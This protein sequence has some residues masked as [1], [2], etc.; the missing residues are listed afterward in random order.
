VKADVRQPRTKTILVAAGGTGGHLFPAQALAIELGKRGWRIELATD[1]RVASYGQDFP[2]AEV[3]LIKSATPSGGGALGKIGAALKLALGTVAA[4]SVIRRV[5]PSAAIGFGGYPTV[6][7]I[8]AASMLGVPC[9]V[10]EA[11]AVL[12]RANKFLVTRVQ[13]VATSSAHVKVSAASG[14]EV[15]ETGNPMRPAVIEASGTPYP[16]RGADDP[17]RL[18]VFG[19]SQGARVFS[20]LV[21]PALE[22]LS[23]GTRARLQITQQCREEDLAAVRAKYDALGLKAELAPFFRDLPARIAGSH[24]VIARSGAGTVSELAVIGRPAIL[25]PL[26]GSIDQDQRANAKAI[27][28]VGGAVLIDQKELTPERLASELSNFIDHPE[29]LAEAARKAKSF[30]RPDA[31]QRLADL[32][33]AVAARKGNAIERH[34]STSSG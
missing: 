27:A 12:G 17:F 2:A 29:R 23:P 13:A 20:E 14:T 32:V 33:E 11:N 31:V 22:K 21:P 6:P 26:P 10:H 4:T 19:G 18:L 34:P 3:H 15:V 24:L 9:V 1:H 28:D 25:V 8:L 16:S 7:P 5:K 30:G